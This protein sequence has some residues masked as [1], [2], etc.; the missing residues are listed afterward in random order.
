[1]NKYSRGACGSS[2]LLR[3]RTARGSEASYQVQERGNHVYEI[4]GKKKGM[5]DRKTAK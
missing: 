4:K 5:K 1:M 2:V 3:R